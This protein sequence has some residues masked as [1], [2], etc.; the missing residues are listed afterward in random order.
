MRVTNLFILFCAASL[1]LTACGSFAET[2]SESSTVVT[3][4]A[5][6]GTEGANSNEECENLFDDNVTTKWCTSSMD[7]PYVIWETSS[8]I[9]VTGYS[10]TTANDNERYTGRNPSD[11]T[12]Y[13]YNGSDAPGTDSSK[14]EIITQVE[15]DTTLKDVNYTQ[16]TFELSE[17]ASKYNYYMLVIDAVQ[18]GSTMQMS[19]F[20]LNF[21]G[22][23]TT[24]VSTTQTTT[25]DSDDSGLEDESAI[26]FVGSTYIYDGCSYDLQVGDSISLYNPN[27]PASTYYAYY[28]EVSSGDSSLVTLDHSE[29]GSCFV[30]ANGVGTVEVLC[31]L[32]YTFV[33]G[34]IYGDTVV[35]EYT[36]TINI[37]E[38]GSTLTESVGSVSN[39]V[40]PRC[41]GA[42][43]ID[44]VDGEQLCPWCLGSKKWSN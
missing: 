7:H 42:G 25:S 18:S 43:T 16:Y 27:V 30:M 4:A 26:Y 39:G 24:A 21:S 36:I 41:H 37:S 17:A 38:R 29:D 31:G 44:T 2:S 1:L 11:W 5:I 32:Q 8:A 23:S 40:C 28:W 22:G 14:W 15:N 3:A 12:L 34:Y 9:A 33:T 13:G 10:I 19:E 35:R 6:S 20:V